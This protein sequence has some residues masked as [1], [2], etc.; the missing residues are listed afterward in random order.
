MK[1]YFTGKDKIVYLLAK[2]KSESKH[3]EKVI[4][5]PSLEMSEMI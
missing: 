5:K 4:I 3:C 1:T 2:K